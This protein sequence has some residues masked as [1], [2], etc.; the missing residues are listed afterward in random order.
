MQ[1]LVDRHRLFVGGRQFV[2]GCLE[3]VDCALQFLAGGIEFL[4][5]LEDMRRVGGLGPFLAARTVN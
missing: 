2:I 1:L 4:L 5:E 3:V